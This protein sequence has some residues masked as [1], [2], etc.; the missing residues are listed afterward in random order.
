MSV[1]NAAS[2]YRALK[3]Q[4]VSFLVERTIGAYPAYGPEETDFWNR[5]KT[6]LTDLWMSS[7]PDRGVF[8]HPVVE[9]KFAYPLCGKTIPQL[10]EDKVLAKAMRGFVPLG[11]LGP[12]D[13]PYVH[14][15]KAIEASK[16]KNIIVASGTGSGKTECF[17]YSMINNLLQD[18]NEDLSKP[19]VRI[20]MIY[21]MNALVKDQLRRIV[22]MVAGKS[23]A[24]SVGMYT[25]QTPHE[26]DDEPRQPWEHVDGDC[27]KP[28]ISAQYYKRSRDIIR[29][30][31]K[32][33]PGPPHI[34]IT[35]Y[36]ML[37][38]MMLRRDDVPIFDVSRQ[39]LRAIVLDEAHLYSGSKGNDIN[40]LIRRTLD[41]FDASLEDR[42]DIR[43][44]RLYATSA[45][46][47]N[48]RKEE[49]IEAASALFGAPKDSF[50]AITGDRDYYKTNAISGWDVDANVK[51][52][53]CKLVN[54]IVQGEAEVDANG[55]VTKQIGPKGFLEISEEDLDLLGRIPA[56]ATSDHGDGKGPVLPYK[57][58]VFNQSPNH[59]YSDMAIGP[60]N[61][62]C[63]LG[64]LQRSAF[65]VND[66]TGLE[67]FTTNRSRK[68]FYF[69]A[70]LAA[71][72]VSEE[73]ED[74]GVQPDYWMFSDI[75]SVRKSAVVY[76]RLSVPGIDTGRPHFALGESKSVTL[77]SRVHKGWQV[78]PDEN[79]PYVFAFQDFTNITQGNQASKALFTALD[80]DSGWCFANGD[81]LVEFS[82]VVSAAE[83]AG[84]TGQF[85]D[86]NKET[87]YR[88]GRR[89]MPIGFVPQSLR[90]AT[91][92][93]L[94]FPNL[95]DGRELTDEDSDGNLMFHPWKGRQMLFFSDS[96]SGAA[97]SAVVLQKSHHDEMIRRYVREGLS[98]GFFAGDPAEAGRPVSFEDICTSMINTA[99]MRDQFSLPEMLY[100][101]GRDGSAR[102]GNLRELRGW[103]I[104]ALVFQELAIKRTGPR[105]LEGLGLVNVSVANDAIKPSAEKV[106]SLIRGD[107]LDKGEVWKNEIVPALVALFRKRRKIVS[108]L[109]LSVPDNPKNRE[110]KAIH[111]VVLN[112]F[113]YIYSDLVENADNR[114]MTHASFADWREG[115]EFL[116]R[117]FIVT[118]GEYARVAKSLFEDS[119][120]RGSI[121]MDGDLG[122]NLFV[123]APRQKDK[124]WGYALNADLLRYSS[125]PVEL[126]VDRVTNEIVEHG[127]R[128]G[129][130]TFNVPKELKD[131]F[132]YRR[133][134]GGGC[135]KADGLDF[136]FD[137]SPF[138]GLRVPE[139]SAQLQ[140]K[141]LSAVEE[142]FKHQ[143]INVISC[144]PTME[145]GVDIGGL[146]AVV[147]G[148]LPP[149]KSSYVQ[150]AGRAGRRDDY[151]A[152]VLTMTGKDI[153]DTA[154]MNDP[155]SLFKRTNVFAS[156]DPSKAS[157]RMQVISHLNQF[158]I[159]E[160]FRQEGGPIIA[161]HGNPMSAWDCAGNF[162]ASRAVMEKYETVLA[163]MME[164]AEEEWIKKRYGDDLKYL[165]N[166][167]KAPPADFPRC[168]KVKEVLVPLMKQPDFLSRVQ[169]IVI[170]T[171]VKAAEAGNLVDNL[172]TALN[173][174]SATYS[175]GLESLLSELD[176][177]PAQHVKRF[178]GHQF[179]NQYRRMLI[180]CLSQAGILPSYGFP[181]NIVTLQA[182]K[183]SIERSVF[184]AIRDFTPGSNLTIAHEKFTVS[185]LTGNFASPDR[186]L[187][188]KHT[189][190]Q[191]AVCG[192]IHEVQTKAPFV[193]ACTTQIDPLRRKNC[194]VDDYVTPQ[195]YRSGQRE[196]GRDAASVLGGR[197]YS[198][199]E[200]R[201]VHGGFTF[202]KQV[203]GHP[204]KA[205]FRLRRM[206]DP[207]AVRAFCVNRGRYGEGFLVDTQSGEIISYRQGDRRVTEWC[208]EHA[209]NRT[210]NPITLA[211][212]SKVSALLC[213]FPCEDKEYHDLA[214]LRNL[215]AVALQ[216]EATSF[217]ELQSRDI[218]QATDVGE[219]LVYVYLYD[220]SG[221]S[222]YMEELL[223]NKESILKGALLRILKCK[224]KRDAGAH[225]VNYTTQRTLG[226]MSD[227]DF[228]Q[229]VDWV[230]K[231]AVE[232]TDGK[233]E[234][235]ET[236]A[237]DPVRYEVTSVGAFANPLAEAGARGTCVTI[238]VKDWSGENL[239]KKLVSVIGYN[240]LK[241]VNVILDSLA[242]RD[243][244]A[245]V[246]AEM[247][248]RLISTAQAADGLGVQLRYFEVKFA[249]NEIGR[250]YRHGIR[251]AVGDKWYLQVPAERMHAAAEDG[252]SPM[253]VR[254][255]L[256]LSSN[257]AAYQ[258]F[259]DWLIVENVDASKWQPPA[260]SEV[261]AE[262][263]SAYIV[264][265]DKIIWLKEGQKYSER[266]LS[267]LFNELEL[268]VTHSVVRAIR[269]RDPYFYTSALWKTLLLTLTAMPNFA[270]DA[271]VDV[272]AA[273]FDP[274]KKRFIYDMPLG[275]PLQ[276]RAGRSSSNDMLESDAKMFADF[277]SSV[278]F[279][280]AGRVNVEYTT[281][282]LGHAR[283]ME[284]DLEKDGVCRTHKL[285]FD[286]GL[287]FLDFKTLNV[288]LMSPA[289]D[290]WVRYSGDYYIMHENP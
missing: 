213:A 268:D 56:T 269:Y 190:V 77:G 19:G 84:E 89:L 236:E 95:A 105:F 129:N 126:Q 10:I 215:L 177:E 254:S 189:L 222:C 216:A 37:E 238:L 48:N 16:T 155:L 158:L 140:T 34:L 197:V 192:A 204:A 195:G 20:L 220:T 281:V 121:P 39:M 208:N 62:S 206:S 137:P 286:R 80:V 55:T 6:Y 66:V 280:K 139:H 186:Y 231:H 60:D 258:F 270:T 232:L 207:N 172:Q 141:V 125:A 90:S 184:A 51:E 196:D 201:L 235:Y 123:R 150:R 255:L 185:A 45:T 218:Q 47:R 173:A 187:F 68:E 276:A 69:K 256:E 107:V 115:R 221:T 93:E 44:V 58:H 277:V 234:M 266:D 117:Y 194:K 240:K 153:S 273:D 182:G 116:D 283:I 162:L 198:P 4:Y 156:A 67:C 73:D 241:K 94:L 97:E 53:A 289:V 285:V 111:R 275:G 230:G 282:D 26:E 92:A 27:S 159:D 160:F 96:R 214:A 217:L 63:P 61:P 227:E 30:G 120:H 174:F 21:P 127:S 14:Q 29:N 38:Y 100:I 83:E 132:Y 43:G 262:D 143:R 103:L 102:T 36:S 193:C 180:A 22:E 33:H 70:R 149:E 24:I 202:Q 257:D 175:S 72:D 210:A 168:G 18:P 124:A 169:R 267:A 52:E 101:D 2:A 165:R 178:L 203:W 104:R 278:K 176:A 233:F 1:F 134:A 82:G 35:N 71:T 17:L 87:S 188:E 50:E 261:N 136:S 245:L 284:I 79:G 142:D 42:P 243:W 260:D 109:V 128:L 264:K 239:V 133:Y 23:P 244:P 183:H 271:V 85:V 274:L 249:E 228:T 46:I 152:I 146:S 112:G 122:T 41:R 287:D 59:C 15:L 32:V 219:G 98:T 200:T 76:F 144:T 28:K 279:G 64:N 272:K 40:M 248:N 106:M 74:N 179:S 31:T 147:Q 247:R 88:P 148:N 259:K 223:A 86:R 154:V 171:S 242:E 225:L 3:Q 211:T 65:Y 13:Q 113:G 138:G 226:E 224:T 199:A 288:G 131:S 290:A 263:V 151:S 12:I 167:L 57:L 161:D 9:A 250:L 252:D 119:I 11:K 130:E 91:L 25:G 135:I 166:L 205:Q 229:A 164:S 118:D 253:L 114:L 49:L 78:T 54:K 251:F 7:D 81:R 163:E 237:P 265:G 170:G 99:E 108:K 145:V 246:K 5:A 212:T 157:A 8:S 181:I 209:A 110:E 191:C 75:T